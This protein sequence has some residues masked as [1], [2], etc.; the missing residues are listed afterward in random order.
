MGNPASAAMKVAKD[1]SLPAGRRIGAGVTAGAMTLANTLGGPAAGILGLLGG[2]FN[3]LG[4]HQDTDEVTGNIRVSQGG[5]LSGDRRGELDDMGLRIPGGPGFE[6]SGL[7]NNFNFFDA[8]A[9]TRPD[10][11]VDYKGVNTNSAG[12]RNLSGLEN[13]GIGGGIYDG[14]ATGGWGSY[15]TNTAG[16]S[17]WGGGPSAQD[18][19]AADQYESDNYFA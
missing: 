14:D 3:S 19:D 13:F 17:G 18:Q 16:N 2:I 7:L 6:Q 15:D 10:M 9:A 12:G 4:F 11:R 5:T 1:D 8:L